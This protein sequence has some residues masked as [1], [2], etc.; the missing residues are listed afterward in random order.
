MAGDLA[1]LLREHRVEL[2]DAKVKPR[3]VADL[4][5]LSSVQEIS[6]A[7][8][9]AA[10][11]AAFETGEEIEKIVEAR[12]L[13]Q[14][15]DTGALDGVIAEVIA[16]NPGPVEQFRSGKEGAINALVGQVMK[17][18]KGSANPKLTADLLRE[19]LSG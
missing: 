19:R 3:H 7:G 16:E 10:L 17:K 8:A 4:V 6:S 15:S 12:G 13:K 2:E 1:A 11:A 9:K 18:T 5:R 14:V